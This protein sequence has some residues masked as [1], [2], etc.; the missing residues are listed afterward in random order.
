MEVGEQQTCPWGSQ[1]IRGPRMFPLSLGTSQPRS[2]PSAGAAE[3]REGRAAAHPQREGEGA[4]G[5]HGCE[6]P[7]GWGLPQHTTTT[8]P[9]K[10]ICGARRSTS[11]ARGPTRSPLLTH[12]HPWQEERAR[13]EEEE[14]R[15][16]AEEEARKKKA[17]S[18]ML[19]FGGYMQKVGGYT[20]GAA[21]LQVFWGGGWATS[22]SWRI[23]RCCRERFL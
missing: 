10:P 14:A 15:K 20:W 3:G 5:P 22:R 7:W 13:K 4:P 2:S 1:G 11:C 6:H 23:L 16:K 8:T 21:K 9:H 17:F 18:N 12:F 19:H